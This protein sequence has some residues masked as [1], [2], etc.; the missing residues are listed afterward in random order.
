MDQAG[1]GAVCLAPPEHISG[2]SYIDFFPL[3]PGI[4][5]LRERRA[6]N[7]RRYGPLVDP[8]R[9]TDPHLRDI[10]NDDS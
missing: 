7:Y 6:V 2:A 3:A 1:V 8:L 10:A 9:K 5:K 4:S